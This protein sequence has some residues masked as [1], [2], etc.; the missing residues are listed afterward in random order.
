[1]PLVHISSLAAAG[2]AAGRGAALAKTIRRDPINAV[3]PQQAEGE[4]VV[5]GRRGLRWIDPAAGRRLRA[6]RSGAAAAVQARR[7]AACCRSSAAPT[8]RI[9]S[10]TSRLSSATIAA[11]IDR[12]RL[13]ANRCSSGI[14][15]RSTARDLLEAIRAAV[16][17]RGARRAACRMAVTR[18]GGLGGDLVGALRRAAAALINARRYAE[19][20]AEGFV[21]RV[22]RLRDRL[23]IVA[24]IDLRDG[25]G[26][27]GRVVSS[28]A[29]WIV[30]VC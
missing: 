9:R 30:D 3:R 28:G 25:L 24:Q 7:S 10:S 2:P 11:A 21:C 15:S 20:A 19:L 29:G 14:R 13:S 22:D 23:G 18:A 26:R 16:G 8:P 4:R 1:M 27:H 12:P 5:A 6:G 17:A